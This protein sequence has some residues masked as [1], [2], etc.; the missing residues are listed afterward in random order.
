[1]EGRKG[2]I[3]GRRRASKK[4]RKMPIKVDKLSGE[5]KDN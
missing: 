1:M 2:N 4:V 3:R 5:P